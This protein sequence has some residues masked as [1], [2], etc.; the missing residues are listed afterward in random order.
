[1]ANPNPKS[2]ETKES[3]ESTGLREGAY[4][5]DEVEIVQVAHRT[6]YAYGTIAATLKSGKVWVLAPN[7]TKGKLNRILSETRKRIGDGYT[8]GKGT[9]RSDSSRYVLFAT[10]K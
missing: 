1:M 3:K 4:N 10:K 7:L 5:A 8:V 6:K 9:L 2:K